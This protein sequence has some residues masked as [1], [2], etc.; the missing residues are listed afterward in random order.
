MSTGEELLMK[1]TLHGSIAGITRKDVS[2]PYFAASYEQPRVRISYPVQ[3][4]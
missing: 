1:G 4:L 2:W 3:V